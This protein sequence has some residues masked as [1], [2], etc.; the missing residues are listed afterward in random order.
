MKNIGIL[1][2][3]FEPNYGF[4]L[5]AYA[6]CEILKGLDMNPILLNRG[7]NRIQSGIFYR[8]KRLIYYKYFC[9]HLDRFYQNLPVTKCVRSSESLFRLCKDHRVSSIVIGSDQ[10][11]SVSNTRGVGLDFFGGFLPSESDIVRYSYASSFGKDKISITNQEQSDIAKLLSQFKGISVRENSG[12]NI[13]HDLFNVTGT[14]VLDPTLLLSISDYQNLIKHKVKNKNILT[15]YILDK[16]IEKSSAIKDFAHKRGLKIRNLYNRGWLPYYSVEYW[17]Q[18]IAE[19]K[20]IVVDSYH[21]MIFA[22][23]FQKDFYVFVNKKRGETRFVSLLNLL[24]LNDRLIYK[25][26]DI[27]HKTFSDIDFSKTL[28]ILENERSRSLDV[29]K[30]Y[31]KS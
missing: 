28:H 2:L 4:L 23:I 12:L 13:L 29:L 26:D 14:W 22:L 19:A 18:S 6:L 10:V 20:T 31:T 9:N 24:N 8:I 15:T 1:T 7:W 30:S 16:S 11:W 5:Q 27:N 17:L 3:P 25:Y 21:G